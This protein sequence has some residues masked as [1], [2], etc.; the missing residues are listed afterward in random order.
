MQCVHWFFF[1]MFSSSI[2]F[3]NDSFGSRCNAESTIIFESMGDRSKPSDMRAAA[4]S[5]WI[6]LCSFSSRVH[7]NSIGHSFCNNTLCI[8]VQCTC[9]DA[10]NFRNGS[11]LNT[12]CL[13]IYALRRT[14]THMWRR[15]TARF[16]QSDIRFLFGK[17]VINYLQN[18]SIPTVL[19]RAI[20]LY[21]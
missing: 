16:Q 15:I 12:M 3:R 9:A 11:G 17:N 7:S 5:Y 19:I 4:F 13:F 6:E 18:S 1:L 8:I 10:I 2:H 21:V 14:Q 20:N